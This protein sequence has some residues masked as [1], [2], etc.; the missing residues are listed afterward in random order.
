MKKI[1]FLTTIFL[2]TFIFISC[3]NDNCRECTNC[4]TKANTT[5]CEDDFEKK[6]NFDDEV[7]VMISDGCTCVDK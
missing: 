5:L 2:P 1:A 6:S 7:D 4:K 3:G